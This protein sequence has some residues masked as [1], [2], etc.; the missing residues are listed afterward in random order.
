ML[1]NDFGKVKLLILVIL[2]APFPICVI[3]SG[4]VTIL[5]LPHT[6]NASLPILVT[7]SGIITSSICEFQ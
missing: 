5:S 7:E 4:K 2:K 1:V 3:E 6:S